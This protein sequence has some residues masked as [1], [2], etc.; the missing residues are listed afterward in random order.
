MGE[1]SSLFCNV[2]LRVGERD[3]WVWWLRE[4]GEFSVETLRNMIDNNFLQVL[5]RASQTHWCSIVPRKVC[6]FIWRL[7]KRRVPV[8]EVLHDKLID[9]HFL[10]CPCCEEQIES[11]DHCFIKCP[12]ILHLW[13]QIFRWW[14]GLSRRQPRWMIFLTIRTLLM[15]QFLVMDVTFGR[16][17]YGA[18]YILFGYI[19]TIVFSLSIRF[20]KLTGSSISNCCRLIGSPNG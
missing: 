17:W 2:C 11:I 1:F 15:F 6:I 7:R 19:V 4:D 13:S 20:I 16:R 3:S 8:R 10:P 5:D 14:V 9:L 18:L 12:K